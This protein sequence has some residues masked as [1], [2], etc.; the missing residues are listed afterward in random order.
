[1]PDQTLKDTIL[2]SVDLT[3]GS[4]SAVSGGI[5]EKHC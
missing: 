3:S 2:M 5:T 4:S 1:M